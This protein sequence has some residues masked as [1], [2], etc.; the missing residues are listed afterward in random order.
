MKLL[1]KCSRGIANTV[2]IADRCNVEL[3]FNKLH[4]PEFNVPENRDAFEY[5]TELCYTG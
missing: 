5:L 1:V 3:E 2:K 4:L